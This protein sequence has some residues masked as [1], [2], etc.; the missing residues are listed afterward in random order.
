M[1][2]GLTLEQRVQQLEAQIQL[3]KD[4]VNE[5]CGPGGPSAGRPCRGGR[6]VIVSGYQIETV[7]QAIDILNKAGVK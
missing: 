2:N 7:E 1:S 4:Q 5:C 3:I 6:A